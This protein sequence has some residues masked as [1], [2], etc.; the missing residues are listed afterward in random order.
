MYNADYEINIIHFVEIPKSS[1]ILVI[2]NPCTYCLFQGTGN[3][4][5]V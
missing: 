5:N 4:K 2:I 3:D 1:Y